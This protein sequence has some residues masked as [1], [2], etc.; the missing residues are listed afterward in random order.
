MTRAGLYKCYLI[1][2][3]NSLKVQIIIHRQNFNYQSR[4]HGF[5]LIIGH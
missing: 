5:N 2:D 1:R 4:L 3:F